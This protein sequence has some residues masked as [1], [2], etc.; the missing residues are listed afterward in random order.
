[1]NFVEQVNYYIFGVIT[2]HS[3][4]FVRLIY[5]ILTSVRFLWCVRYP[6]FHTLIR[7][8]YLCRV[9]CLCCEAKQISPNYVSV[10]RT[11]SD[12]SWRAIVLVVFFFNVLRIK[13]IFDWFSFWIL[14]RFSGILVA[15]LPKRFDINSKFFTFSFCFSAIQASFWNFQNH[16]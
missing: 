11:F 4:G 14:L 16:F 5:Q 7:Y 10:P 9:F 15:F 2:I 6:Q 13:W 8:N 1:M 12:W 3:W